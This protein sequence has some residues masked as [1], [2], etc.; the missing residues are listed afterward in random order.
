MNGVQAILGSSSVDNPRQSE[1]FLPNRATPIVARVHT[2]TAKGRPN[3]KDKQ[4]SASA[5]TPL[6][7]STED[8]A[9]KESRGWVEGV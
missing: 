3:T 7:S 1:L 4:K 2:L 9:V 5:E 6:V 8:S